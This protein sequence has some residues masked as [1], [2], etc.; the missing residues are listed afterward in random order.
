MT[1]GNIGSLMTDACFRARAGMNMSHAKLLEYLSD[2]DRL[3]L[4]AGVGWREEYVGQYQVAP[5]LDTPI[6]YAFA[7]GEPVAI[8][9]YTK[10]SRFRYPVILKDHACVASINVPPEPALATFGVLEVDA[11]A[12]S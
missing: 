5:D 1:E 12:P 9:D 6:G 2:R 3:I 8:S 11:V 10:E 4:R 7:L